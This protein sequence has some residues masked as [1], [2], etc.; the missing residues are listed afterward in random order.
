MMIKD[1]RLMIE[2]DHILKEEVLEKY[3][4]QSY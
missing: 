2:L 1:Y 4:E 3:V